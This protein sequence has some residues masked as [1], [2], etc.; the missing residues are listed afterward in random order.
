M[1]HSSAFGA[2]ARRSQGRKSACGRMQRYL[3]SFHDVRD[4][5][6]QH[7]RASP[8]G[9]QRD[10]Q[11]VAGVQHAEGTH[12]SNEV[13][14]PRSGVPHRELGYENHTVASALAVCYAMS[15]RAATVLPPMMF[16]CLGYDLERHPPQGGAPMT[17][18]KRPCDAGACG[19]FS[20]TPLLS[21]WQTRGAPSA[22]PGAPREPAY[23]P[24]PRMLL[25][26]LGLAPAPV[27]RCTRSRTS[28]SRE[29]AILL[30]GGQ[31]YP[32]VSSWQHLHWRMGA[33]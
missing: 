16:V 1:A 3:S 18:E 24:L 14:Q 2:G 28:T 4:A 26:R 31:G 22:P 17:K 21:L 19:A 5:L 12:V 11:S 6:H 8:Q 15:S 20:Q 10:W 23:Y 33:P 7:T 30:T 32:D 27:E 9:K 25:H 13:H 29:S